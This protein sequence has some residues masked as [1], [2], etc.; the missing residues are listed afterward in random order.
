MLVK[1]PEK[2]LAKRRVPINVSNMP[3]DRSDGRLKR[4]PL[5]FLNFRSQLKGEMKIASDAGQAFKPVIL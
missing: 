4:R 2:S 1:R 3:G 5:E